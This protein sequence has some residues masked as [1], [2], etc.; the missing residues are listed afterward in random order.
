MWGIPQNEYL[1]KADVWPLNKEGEI[2]LGLKIEDSFALENAEKSTKIPGIAF[3]EWGPTDMGFWLLGMPGGGARGGGG[4]AN[5]PVMQAARAR[6]LAATKAAGI[7]F[8]NTCTDNNVGQ[9]L[10]DGVKICTGGYNAGRK[11][12]KNPWTY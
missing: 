8:L 11:L 5:Q 12:T 2:M 9:M 3:A 7:A 1:R 6:V 10:Q 4:Q